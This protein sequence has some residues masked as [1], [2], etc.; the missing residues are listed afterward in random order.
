MVKAKALKLLKHDE[1]LDRI[2]ETLLIQVE[3][4]NEIYKLQMQRKVF[5]CSYLPKGKKHL[6]H[7]HNE[8][9]KIK[10]KN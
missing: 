6:L 1:W 7:I 3:Q 8:K 2:S 10:K 9:C 5:F 4:E